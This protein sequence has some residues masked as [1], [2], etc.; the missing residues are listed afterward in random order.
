ML[1]APRSIF[2]F[3]C[4]W[5]AQQ[6]KEQLIRLS[7]PGKTLRSELQSMSIALDL[8]KDHAVRATVAQYKTRFEEYVDE[9]S[10]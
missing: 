4:P 3:F 10:G 1:L 9:Y 6:S 2:I 5:G 7:K 8:P